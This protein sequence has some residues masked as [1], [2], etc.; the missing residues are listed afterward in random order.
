MTTR[1]DRRI[2][3]NLAKH[4]ARMAELMI[5]GMDKDAASKQA[6]EEI[7]G[8]RSK[9]V[10]TAPGHLSKATDY[11]CVASEM[12]AIQLRKGIAEMVSACEDAERTVRSMEGQ[13]TATT[14][15]AIKTIGQIQKRFTQAVG[16]IQ[17]VMTNATDA[18]L[19]VDGQ[20]AN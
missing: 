7:I 20:K 18:A 11:S 19:L 6:F 5:G 8:I 10:Q 16:S 15:A 9:L 2:K 1:E 14:R 17:H 3:N 4:A 12:V 13:P